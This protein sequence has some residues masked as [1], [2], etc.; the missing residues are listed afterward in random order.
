MTM[1][2]S[3]IKNRIKNLLRS[4]SIKLR[5]NKPR[6]NKENLEN[7]VMHPALDLERKYSLAYG[8]L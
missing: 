4:P 6:N 8:A 5:R 3:T 1:E 2:N 7:K